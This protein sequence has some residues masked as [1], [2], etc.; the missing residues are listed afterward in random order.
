[1]IRF[2]KTKEEKLEGY[3]RQRYTALSPENK[4]E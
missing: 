1:M 4:H 2:Q 3:A